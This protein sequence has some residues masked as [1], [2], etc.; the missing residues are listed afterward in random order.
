M[1]TL[2]LLDAP[3]SVPSAGPA[4]LMTSRGALP[5]VEIA[6]EA[7]IDGLVAG[8]TLRQVF[9]NAYGEPLEALYV[10]PLPSRAAVTSFRLEVAGRVVEGKLREKGEARRAYQQAIRH[11]HR[12]A[13]A[14]EEE[15]GT[16]TM[17]VGNIPPGES[18]TVTLQMCAPLPFAD[19]EATYRF[20]LVVA[21]RYGPAIAP[22]ATSRPG[23]GPAL[24][25]TV[26]VGESALAPH[27]FRS[28]LHTVEESLAGGTRRFRA[29]A[30]ERPDRDFVLRWRV[31][32]EKIRT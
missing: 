31:T 16:F 22:P 9:V 28:T 21:P 29:V 23:A 5:L 13:L 30:G 32:S 8:T 19:G 11:G 4:A 20:P 14:E 2:P 6:V 25:I 26:D 1:P 17:K 18:A 12:A 3:A 15:P 10:F 24:S 27:A 7:R